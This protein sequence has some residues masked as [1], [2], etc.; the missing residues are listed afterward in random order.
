VSTAGTGRGG[1]VV[2]VVVEVVG[3][4]EVVTVE[5]VGTVAGTSVVDVAWVPE[6]AEPG[7]EVGPV[8]VDTDA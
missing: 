6:V 2:V 8:V 3:T 5:V 7:D 1:T 4:V